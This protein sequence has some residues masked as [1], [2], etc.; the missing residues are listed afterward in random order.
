[1]KLSEPMKAGLLKIADIAGRGV[2]HH[3]LMALRR[4]GLI[5]MERCVCGRPM[6]WGITRDGFK[7]WLRIKREKERKR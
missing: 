7:E 4:R 5:R 2:N 3:T 1:M 6:G